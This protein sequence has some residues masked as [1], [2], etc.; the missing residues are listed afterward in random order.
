MKI[1]AV[2]KNPD[3]G[4]RVVQTLESHGACAYLHLGV[5][6]LFSN[7][8]VEQ[9][10][11]LIAE[12]DERHLSTWISLLMPR[13]RSDVPIVIYGPGTCEAMTRALCF[14]AHDYASQYED[15]AALWRRLSARL[16]AVRLKSS[17]ST[18]QIGCYTLD[19]NCQQLGLG[20]A[21]ETLTT[22]EVALL[23][24]LA[25]RPGWVITTESIC[26]E[27]CR[28]SA[29][30]SH[31]SIEQHIYR[32]RK[33][34]DNL[35]RVARFDGGLRLASVYGVG[36]RL[37]LLENYQPGEERCMALRRAA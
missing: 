36:Y 30:I 22:R 11:G 20:E 23:A 5:E 18:V 34:I 4:A 32:L 35:H 1:L 17:C 31:R 25:T 2:F 29:D 10:D 26:V 28:R 33:K 12:D 8:D 3:L 21:A 6:R 14:G 37:D 7:H 19:R 15:V 24:A 27:V 9:M 16:E 13:L